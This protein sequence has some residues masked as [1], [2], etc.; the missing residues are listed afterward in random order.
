MT[1]LLLFLVAGVTGCFIGSTLGLL[2]G[3]AADVIFLSDQ[4]TGPG[5]VGVTYAWPGAML[6]AV[7]GAILAVIWVAQWLRARNPIR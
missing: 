3:A 7:F 2:I 4:A 1:R 5:T 6:G